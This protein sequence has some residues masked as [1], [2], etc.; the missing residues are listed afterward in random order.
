MERTEKGIYAHAGN[1]SGGETSVQSAHG[2]GS[3][4]ELRSVRMFVVS[5]RSN[6]PFG[7][8]V[9]E[10]FFLSPSNEVSPFPRFAVILFSGVEYALFISKMQME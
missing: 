8:S 4:T 2:N 6:L 10:L 9:V 1:C 3:K 5:F 7:L